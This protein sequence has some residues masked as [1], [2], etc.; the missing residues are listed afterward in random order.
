V[1]LL[2]K[3]LGLGPDP[4]EAMI[5]LYLSIVAEARQPIWYAEMGVPDTLDGR[6]DMISAILALIFVRLEAEGTAGRGPN[7]R[8]TEVFIDDM[9]GQLRQLGIGDVIVGKHIGKMMSAMGGRL[10]IYRDTLGDTKLFEEALVRNLWRGEPGVDAKPG[11]VAER[12]RT[13]A[14]KINATDWPTLKAQGL[15]A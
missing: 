12:L 8:L 9:D 13:L 6:F 5:P 4:R 7:A 14:A 3:L 11:L 1:T 2:K 15:P 10:S